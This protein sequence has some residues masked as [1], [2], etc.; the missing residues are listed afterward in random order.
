MGMARQSSTAGMAVVA[1]LL[2][3]AP[4]VRAAGLDPALAS[5]LK[6]IESAFRS[7]DAASL[8]PAFSATAKVRVDLKDVMDGPGSYGPSQL[9]VIFGRI[10]DVN[11]TR[12]FSFRDEDVTV[13][14]PGVAFARGKWLRKVRL[15]G[16][17]ATDTVTFT[18]R[19]ESG[20]DW[21]IHEIRSSK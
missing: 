17:D 9:E 19:Q 7:G 21:R 5:R 15:G 14:P 18:L 3:A 2:T 10:F 16:A 1:M 6:R 4:A 11:R 8:R 12:E 20:G 13:S